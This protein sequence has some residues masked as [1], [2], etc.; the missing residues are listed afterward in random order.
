M[1]GDR[2]SDA[3]V[4]GGGGG[5]I[6]SLG[7]AFPRSTT[8]RHRALHVVPRRR[9]RGAPRPRTLT[10][11][12]VWS[13]SIPTS[14]NCTET[15]RLYASL[16]IATVA[17]TAALYPK[18]S[19][20]VQAGRPTHASTVVVAIRHPHDRHTALQTLLPGNNVTVI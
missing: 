18:F 2:W 16:V 7:A 20:K 13:R 10:R 4:G 1:L 14:L 17:R 6:R 9:R 11:R 3:G 15:E 12:R 8:V 19:P 5:H